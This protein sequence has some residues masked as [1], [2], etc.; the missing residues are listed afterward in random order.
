MHVVRE[1]LILAGVGPFSNIASLSRSRWIQSP[2]YYVPQDAMYERYE[3]VEIVL[4][5]YSPL[6][7]AYEYGPSISKC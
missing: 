6:P 4:D 3:S 2:C 7:Y 1:I 5:S